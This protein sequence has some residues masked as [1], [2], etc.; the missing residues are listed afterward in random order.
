MLVFVQ[1]IDNIGHGIGS[2]IFMILFLG[3]SREHA[4][5]D[6]SHART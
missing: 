5:C 6:V 3:P 4:C 1:G 2:M